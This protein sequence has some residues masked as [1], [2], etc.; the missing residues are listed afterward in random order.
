MTKRFMTL[1]FAAAAM[2]DIRGQAAAPASDPPAGWWSIPKTKAI[3]KIG[4]Y[5]KLDLIHDFQPIGSPD[6]FD[7]S[8]I[9]TDGSEGQT[10]H[11]NAKE[12]RLFLDVK[13]PT[14]V[15]EIRTYVEG[16]FYG[17]SGGFRMRHAFIEIGGR[18]LAGQ[19]WSNF[20][21]ENIIP[22]T[23]DFEKPA[24]YTF[25]RH[26][27]LRYK[28]P[29]NDDMYLAFALE[30]PSTNAQTPAEAGKFESPLPDLTARF[31]IT[32]PWGHVQL[33]AFAGKLDYRYATGELTGL[34]LY[35]GNLSGQ[36]NVLDKKDKLFYQ[37]VAGP[38][39]GRYRGGLSAGLD[40]NGELERLMD[41]G[42][43]IGYEHRWSKAF[44]SLALYSLG[45]VDNTAGQ[46]ETALKTTDYVAANLLWHFTDHAFAGV[47][48]L[49]GLRSDLNEADGT[50]N[51][52]QFSVRYA[53]N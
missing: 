42:F 24:A 29:L 6:W 51:R 33:S 25:V 39:V 27:M 53:F 12:T 37:V 49:W 43:T 46:P 13:T 41:A 38:G 7:V 16:D 35:G 45:R 17:S 28:Q 26:P 44:S 20:M 22:N 50:A 11:L 3:F 34:L 19:T 9:P 30:E 18:W 52:L 1:L 2:A 36:F 40:A 15:G 32:K 23:L 5:V 4:G 47:E 10:T 8:K 21:D 14:G 31:R 48:Y